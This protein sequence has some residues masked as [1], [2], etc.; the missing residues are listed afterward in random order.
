MQRERSPILRLVTNDP[1]ERAEPIVEYFR[2]RVQELDPASPDRLRI[3]QLLAQWDE[4][5]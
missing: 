4:E 3:L 1:I 5:R 2:N